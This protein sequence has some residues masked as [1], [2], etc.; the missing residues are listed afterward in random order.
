M[1][2]IKKRNGIY[3][4]DFRY[5]GKRIRKSLGTKNKAEANSKFQQLLI[6]LKSEDNEEKQ[7]IKQIKLNEAFNKFDEYLLTRSSSRNTYKRYIGSVRLFIEFVENKHGNIN[8]DQ[9]LSRDFNDFQ[10]QRLKKVKPKSVNNDRT[11]INEFFKWAGNN[12]YLHVNPMDKTKSIPE[13]D[14]REITFYSVDE[15]KAILSYHKNPHKWKARNKTRHKHVYERLYPFWLALYSTGMRTGEL[16]HLEWDDVN[17]E[18]NEIY[19]RFKDDWKPKS[20]KERVIPINSQ[21]KKAFEIRK[22]LSES[23]KYVFSKGDGSKLKDKYLLDKL[24]VILKNLH[25]QG[26]VHKFRHTFASLHAMNGTDL[27]TLQKLLGHADIATTMKYAHLSNEHI[28]RQAN[29]LPDLV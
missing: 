18:K 11:A 6:H 4:T 27:P 23:E 12:D 7:R 24:R 9:V 29:N 2:S 3:H 15:V 10:T 17:L 1:S 14:N 21:F 5:N 20:S 28:K 22:E 26:N 8:I 19:I 16:Q 13:K 25:I